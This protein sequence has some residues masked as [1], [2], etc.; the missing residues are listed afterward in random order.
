MPIYNCKY[1]YNYNYNYYHNISSAFMS[2]VVVVFLY[3]FDMKSN[4]DTAELKWV[5]SHA[6]VFKPHSLSVLSGLTILFFVFGLLF[7]IFL[8]VSVFIYYYC[9]AS[10]AYSIHAYK[11]IVTGTEKQMNKYCKKYE[12]YKNN[13]QQ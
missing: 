11:Y 7:N 10:Q 2:V 5:S 6:T 13:I 9:V 12:I 8:F 4:N 3:L 1:N